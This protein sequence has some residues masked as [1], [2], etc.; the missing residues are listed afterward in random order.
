MSTDQIKVV[1]VNVKASDSPGKVK[2]KLL[3]GLRRAE[4]KSPTPVCVSQPLQSWS[5]DLHSISDIPANEV[6]QVSSNSRFIV[7]LLKDG[8]V[9]RLKCTSSSS[10][11]RKDSRSILESLQ[12]PT[13]TFQELSDAEYA[14]QLQSDIMS[15]R[16]TREPGPTTIHTM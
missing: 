13:P 11:T 7:F 3:K 14:R 1:C 5:K 4:K 10:S 8:N 15:G 12:R 9:C 2:S 6:A 16:S